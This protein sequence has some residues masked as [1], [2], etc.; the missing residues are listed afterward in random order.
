MRY[1]TFWQRAAVCLFLLLWSVWAFPLDPSK[2]ITQYIHNAWGAEQG[3]T[4]MDVMSIVSTRDGY[5]WLGTIEGLLRFDGVSFTL[6][7]KQNTSGLKQNYIFLL[8]EDRQGNLWIGT[9]GGG[10]SRFKDGKFTAYTTQQGLSNNDIQAIGESKD[11][12]LWIGTNSGLNR[13]KDEKFTTYTTKHGLASDSVRAIQEDKDGNLWVGT[14]NGLNLLQDGHFILYPAILGADQHGSAAQHSATPVTSLYESKTG[15]LW[16]GFQGSGLIRFR[17]GNLQHYTTQDGLT[18]DSVLSIYEDRDGNLWIGTQGG[19]LNRLQDGKL[20]A[21]TT[22]EGLSNN[23]VRAIREDR[24]GSLW[25]GTIGAG[26]LDRLRDGKFLIY[27]TKEGLAGN[28]HVWST[29]EGR[30]GSIWIGGSG[31]A[32]NRFKNGTITSYISKQ[33][34]AAAIV[35]AVY[36]SRDGSVWIGTEDGLHRFKNGKF[37][38]YTTKQ[39]LCHN[40]IWSLAEDKE[41]NL[42]VGTEGGLNRLTNER[43]TTY[44]TEDGLSNHAVRAI[45]VGRDSSIW[46]GTNGGLNRLK[47]GVFTVYSTKNGLSGNLVRSIYEDEAGTLWIGTLGSGLNRFKDGKFATLGVNGGLFD[48]VIWSIVEDRH[49]NLWMSCNRG[50]FQAS[51]K[52][53]DDYAEK[54]TQS[55]PYSAYGRSDGV[56]GASGGSYPAGLRARDGRLWFPTRNGVA[57]IEPDHVISNRQI[58]P[59]FVEKVLA[60]NEALDVLQTAYLKPSTG[61]IEFHYAALSFL[62]PEKVRFKYQLEGFDKGWVEADTRRVAYYTSLWP[63]RYRFRVMACNNDGLWNEVAASFSFQLRPHFYQSWWFYGVCAIAGALVVVGGHRM[64]VKQLRDREKA[65]SLRVEERTAELQQE[66]AERIRAESEIRFQQ[67]RFQ[68][69]FENAPVGIVMLDE[70]DRIVALNPAFEAMFQFTPDELLLKHIND[71]IVPESHGKEA[72]TISRQTLEGKAAQ[73]ETVRQRKDGSLVPVEVYGVPI[74]SDQGL[75]GMYGMYADVSARKQAEEELKKAKELA[76]TANQSKSIF[77]ATMSHEI[78][79]PMNGIIGMTELVLDT[80]LTPEQRSDLCMV[81]ASADSLL[82][83]INDVLDFSKIEAGKL[84]FENIAFEPGR[85]LGEAMKPLAFRAHQ[86]GLELIFEVSSNVPETVVGD[87]VRLRQVLVNLVG[88]AIKFTDQGEIVVRIDIESHAENAVCLHFSVTDTGIGI[89]LEKQKTIFES[90]TQADGSTT[91]RYGGTGLGLAI[92][93]RLVKMMHGNIWVESRPAQ[94]GSI[95]HFTATLG[96]EKEFELNPVPQCVEAL[97]D[98]RALIV[99]DSATNRHLLLEML[100]RWGM[101]PAAVDGCRPALHALAEARRSGEAFQLVLLDA[102]MPEMDGFVAA[103]RMKQTSELDEA[104]I[105]ILSSSGSSADAARCREL[106]ISTCLTKPILQ[107]ELLEAIL[108]TLGSREIQVSTAVVKPVSSQGAGRALHILLAEDNRVNQL[109]AVRLIQ[110]QGHSVSVANNGREALAII[111]NNRFDAVLMDV[112]M[113]EMDG[114]SAASAIRKQ[115]RATGE[116][117]PII[118]MTAHAMS[119]DKERCLAAGMDAYLSKP[120][121]ANQL[122]NVIDDLCGSLRAMNPTPKIASSSKVS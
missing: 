29:S 47:D 70:Q 75:E 118:A 10:L 65:L 36:E 68:Q 109:L 63:G 23:S 120:I 116:H 85:S 103:E 78:R 56:T 3:L 5:L 74:V 117:L 113:P 77:L 96:L 101:K 16:V 71:V 104:K 38:T 40:T 100:T 21:F 99:D 97:R 105:I 115:E 69:L 45:Y 48:D 22:K 79:T 35:R 107:A 27:T 2:A 32:L 98:L 52:A 110:Q 20:T 114:F 92:C 76:E 111:A 13:F 72:S 83:V 4:Q 9:K 39:G 37:S 59:V 42:W 30:D 58:P 54:R 84:D 41:G 14:D 8:F 49:A 57:V 17:G 28:N 73:W 25:I 60:D 67:R 80:P 51:K 93:M 94:R 11:G 95:F 88:N 18:S 53:L 122:F 106:G 112:E 119:G 43:W 46:L 1:A 81:K 89:P 31:G 61:R 19:G 66:I 121:Q 62:A 6:F 64:R 90:F 50:I 7:D 26:G 82:T 87:P 91:R 108:T 12:S 55:I 24:E 33:I 34:P 15:S 44:T 102:H 86:K